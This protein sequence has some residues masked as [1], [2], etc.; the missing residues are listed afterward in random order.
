MYA[1]DDVMFVKEMG[2]V[3]VKDRLDVVQ[4]IIAVSKEGWDGMS[5]MLVLLLIENV[6]LSRRLASS[7]RCP[8]E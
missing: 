2:T 7:P 3:Y 1:K 5:C 8:Q 6:G 4:V